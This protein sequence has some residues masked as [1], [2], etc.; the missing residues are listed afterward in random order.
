MEKIKFEK[1]KLMKLKI[2]IIIKV[3]VAQTMTLQRLRKLL[4]LI[5][6]LVST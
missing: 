4:E 3:L 2:I 6:S 5:L 1:E